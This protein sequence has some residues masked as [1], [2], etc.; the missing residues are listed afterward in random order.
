V[1][2]PS[3]W[4]FKFEV[5]INIHTYWEFEQLSE[6]V[7][8]QSNKNTLR[9]WFTLVILQVYG[10]RS[11][12]RL[13]DKNSVCPTM[14]TYDNDIYVLCRA[15]FIE[16]IVLYECCLLQVKSLRCIS[17]YCFCWC[18]PTIIFFIKFQL[19]TCALCTWIIPYIT[20][21]C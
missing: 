17:P 1:I 18:W 20:E 14:F 11:P 7:L 2:A 4:C 6:N 16:H 3:T 19:D 10:S 9:L 13:R 15:V 5:Q 21:Y 12:R 8:L